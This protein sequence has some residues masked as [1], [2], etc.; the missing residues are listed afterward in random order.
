MRRFWL[1]FSLVMIA[2]VSIPFWMKPFYLFLITEILTLS[3]FAMSFDLVYGY[4]GMLSLGHATF[5]GVGSYI[6]TLTILHWHT[7]LWVSLL[8]AII[9]SMV[10]AWMIGFFAVRARGT[11]FV[12]ITIIFSLVIFYLSFYYK[13]ITGGDDGLPVKI[14]DLPLGV[15]SVPIYDNPLANYLLV[16]AIV[17]LS[18]LFYRR[19]MASPL[20]RV[21]L[22]I[23][24]NE[25]RARYIGFNTL[26]YRMIS[27]AISGALSGLSGALYTMTTHYSNNK[28]LHWTTSIDVVVWTIVGGAGTLVGPVLG[29]T[30]FTFFREFISFH[31]KQYPIVIGL[32]LILF[33]IYVP[34]GLLGLGARGFRRGGK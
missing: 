3:L 29:T 32:V 33:I 23:K 19:L 4:T 15:V 34:Q 31:F 10:F 12:V 9:G 24:S 17:G 14:P 2:L 7:S 16:L 30:I 21:F 11:N 1:S 26:R 20:G 18:Y 25:E 22:A 13:N 5:F 28:L 27:F 6:L 8:L